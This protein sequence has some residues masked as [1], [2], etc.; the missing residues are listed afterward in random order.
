MNKEDRLMNKIRSLFALAAND[1]AT[2]NESENA[3]RMAHKLLIKHSMSMMDLNEV[4]ETSIA[5]II[6]PS[7]PWTRSVFISVAQL[8]TCRY[9][10]DHN[11]DEPLHMI[12]GTKSNRTTAKIVAKQLIEQIQRDTKGKGTAFRNGAVESLKYTCLKILRERKN[13]VE[14][15][16]PGTGLVPMDLM[17]KQMIEVNDFIQQQ[18]GNL[19]RCKSGGKSSDAGREYGK[20]LNP[21]ARVTGAG[22]A[23][24]T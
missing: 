8:Y 15:V 3:L 9:V 14:E 17:K 2:G 24:L 11:C 20:G 22:Q 5:F 16:L 4:D 1:G 21:G 7:N 10:V 12:I 23:R 13:Q 18:F 6:V 19:G